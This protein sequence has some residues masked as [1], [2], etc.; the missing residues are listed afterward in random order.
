MDRWETKNLLIY[1]SKVT[2]RKYFFLS[3]TWWQND[4]VW[5]IMTLNRKHKMSF[6]EQSPFPF[7]SVSFSLCSRV[8]QL[9]GGMGGMQKMRSGGKRKTVGKQERLLK[10]GNPVLVTIWHNVNCSDSV[11]NYFSNHSISII[12]QHILTP[13]EGKAQSFFLITVKGLRVETWYDSIETVYVWLGQSNTHTY[14]HSL[15]WHENLRNL[16]FQNIS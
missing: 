9:E 1:G 12:M 15:H 16:I 7:L 10:S 2:Q 6:T 11:N 8:V 5:R 3:C 4:T 14:N 13:L